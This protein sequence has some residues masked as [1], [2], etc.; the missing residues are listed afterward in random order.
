MTFGHAWF[1]HSEIIF[2]EKASPWKRLSFRVNH[3]AFRSKL[4]ST[5]VKSSSLVPVPV[6]N[7]R[8]VRVR[9]RQCLVAMGMRMRLARRVAR[10]MSVLMMLIV[11]VQVLVLH[12]FVMMQVL[13]AFGEVKPYSHGHQD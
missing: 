6:M 9:V 2:A 5:G 7:V 8:E 11:N 10:G 12:R 13:V 3:A 4:T 1:R